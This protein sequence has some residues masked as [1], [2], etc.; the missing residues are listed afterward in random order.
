MCWIYLSKMD[1]ETLALVDDGYNHFRGHCF[2]GPGVADGRRRDVVETVGVETSWRPF[3]VNRFVL[4]RLDVVDAIRRKTRVEA[5]AEAKWEA[6][7]EEIQAAC[8]G[9]GV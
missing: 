9:A 8:S 2:K 7:R 6:V 3:G 4:R 1:L 5:G